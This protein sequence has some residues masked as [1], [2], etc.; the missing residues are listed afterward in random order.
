MGTT[1]TGDASTYPTSLTIPSGGDRR[2]VSS[3]NTPIQGLANRTEWLKARAIR[4]VLRSSYE[5]EGGTWHRF[6]DT[7]YSIFA[8][9]AVDVT[10]VKAN[11]VLLIDFHATVRVN[12]DSDGRLRVGVIDGYGGVNEEVYNTG[13]V[14]R[15][16]GFAPAGGTVYQH[17]HISNAYV[18]GLDGTT[19]VAVYGKVTGTEAWIDLVD[20]GVL[21]VVH[22]GS[23]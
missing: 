13:S 11:D 17:V 19:R 2:N 14:A 8:G 12:N 15:F 10:G 21:R 7:S 3:V 5:A 9:G 22:L 20:A 23:L 6:D 18:V 16:Y 1:I 4:K